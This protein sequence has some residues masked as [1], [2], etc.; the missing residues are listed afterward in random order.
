MQFT[1]TRNNE[2]CDVQRQKPLNQPSDQ[3]AT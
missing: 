2:Q 1:I 3:H